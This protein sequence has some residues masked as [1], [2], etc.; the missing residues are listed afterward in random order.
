MSYAEA[1]HFAQT[2]GLA[3]LALIFVGVLIYALWPGN[4]EKFKRASETPLQDE[5]NHGR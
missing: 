4:R 3:L 5:D 2:W 1:T